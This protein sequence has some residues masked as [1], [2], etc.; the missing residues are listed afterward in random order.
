MALCLRRI[1]SDDI[2]YRIR[3]K[4]Y[5]YLVD[6]GHAKEHVFKVF[7]EVGRMPRSVAREGKC[8]Q[9]GKHCVFI[10]KYNHR[11]PHIRKIIKKHCSIIDSDVLAKQIL[12][13]ERNRVSY[14]RGK[15]LEELL[16]PSNPFKTTSETSLGCY[17]CTVKRCDGCKNFLI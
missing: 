13:P 4:D 8:K 11:I 3:N 2:E 15:D 9:E 12:P 6:C 1:C 17:S 7:D 14:R 16:A 5:K 10:S